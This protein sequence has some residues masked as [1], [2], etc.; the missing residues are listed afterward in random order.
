M[1]TNLILLL[2]VLLLSNPLNNGT[3]P[4]KTAGQPNINID[5]N[6][7]GLAPVTVTG[8]A[9]L[10]GGGVFVPVLDK[11]NNYAIS[12]SLSYIKGKHAIKTGV[13]LVYRRASNFQS[14][15]GQGTWTFAS[16]QALAQGVFTSVSR[17]N[18]LVS[19]HYRMWEWSA[20]AQDDWH[21][22]EKLTLNM[23]LRWDRY[24]PF[25]EAKGLIANFDPY[26]VAIQV[27][28]VNG[29]SNSAG[30]KNDWFDFAPRFGFAYTIGKGTVLRGGFGLSFFVNNYNSTASL[31]NIPFVATF[32]PWRATRRSPR[33]ALGARRS[34]D[35]SSACRA[36]ATRERRRPTS[37]V[38]RRTARRGSSSATWRRRS[39]W[40]G[41]SAR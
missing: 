1:K 28:G 24:S 37:P 10:G 17:S 15:S 3:N 5:D 16:Y 26:K 9:G 2:A 7:S 38:P 30:V 27:A 6:T 23:G 32:G 22:T 12:E 33:D 36:P 25:T 19:P 8:G 31:Q 14:A 18:V 11:D 29:V 41:R 35:R 21:A 39:R 13:A 20:F 34:W 40:S 4:N